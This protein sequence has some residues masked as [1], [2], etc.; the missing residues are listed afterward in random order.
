M[1][2]DNEWMMMVVVLDGGGG[3]GGR[4]SE[5]LCNDG[6]DEEANVKKEDATAAVTKQVKDDESME[7]E[8]HPVDIERP[9]SSDL[10]FA[11]E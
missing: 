8:H 11:E 9:A 4:A 3:D 10:E 7:S 6:A 1:D 5:P 2:D